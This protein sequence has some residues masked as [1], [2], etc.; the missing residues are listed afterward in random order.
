[1]QKQLDEWKAVKE[2]SRRQED[3][4]GSRRQENR[5]LRQGMENLH[6]FHLKHS[7]SVSSS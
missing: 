2:W 5:M 3:A 7:C 1:M 6:H 4:N